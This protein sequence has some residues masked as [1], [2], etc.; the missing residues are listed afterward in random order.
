MEGPSIEPSTE[1][2]Y[3]CGNVSAMLF[4]TLFIDNAI[5]RSSTRV[6]KYLRRGAGFCTGSLSLGSGTADKLNE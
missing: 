3:L 5:L 2:L 1:D 4:K 6:R